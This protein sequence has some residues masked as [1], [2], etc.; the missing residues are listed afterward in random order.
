MIIASIAMLKSWEW[1]F[2]LNRSI[3]DD[4]IPELKNMMR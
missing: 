1:E 3:V 4:L 2:G